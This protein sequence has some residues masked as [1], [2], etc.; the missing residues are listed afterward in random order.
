MLVEIGASWT[1]TCCVCIGSGVV[2]TDAT[3]QIVRA[4]AVIAPA[5]IPRIFLMGYFFLASRA[6]LIF[7]PKTIQTT[8]AIR[9]MS[10]PI[11][12]PDIA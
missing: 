11:G 10:A 7:L 1:T 4:T 5:A 9:T 3:P 2:L 8:P 6:A 12:E